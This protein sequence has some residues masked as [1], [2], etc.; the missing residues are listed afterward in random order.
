MSERSRSHIGTVSLLVAVGGTLASQVALRFGPFAG[1]EWLRIVGAGFEAAVVGALADWFA[2]TAL[3]RHPLGLPI[4]HTAIIPTRRARLTEGIVSMVQEEWLSPEVIESR[5]ARF[6]PS[7]VISDW[8]SDPE[9]VE[10]LGAPLRDLLHALADVLVEPEVRELAA[11]TLQRQLQAVPIDP[12]LG[13]SLARALE[14]T[15]A[16]AAFESAARSLAQLARRP[17]T[18]ENLQLWL[19]RS[20][21]QLH[22]EG[23]RLIPLILRRK[24]VQR[25]I[26][27]AACDY[28]TGELLG[29]ATDPAHPLR[30]SLFDA[31][32]RFAARIAAGEPELLAQ[33][34]RLRTAVVESLDTTPLLANALAGMRAQL[35]DDL[36][37]QDSHLAQLINRQLRSGI[38]QLLAD[39][40]RRAR[41]DEWVRGTAGDLLRRHHHQIGLTVRE[42]LEALDADALVAQ[43]E[44]RVGA[45]LQFI[46]LNGALVGGLIGLVLAA[47]H[48]LLH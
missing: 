21:E 40:Q 12:S 4:P 35:Q 1:A 10:R 48:A 33:I 11:A 31:A 47:I 6:S 39:P 15:S 27:E 2:V 46:R 13:T 32:R 8:L 23:K 41:I 36:R 34:E 38:R 44:E 9:H 14:S 43:I 20:A 22:R 45:D 26:V 30:R 28:A 17:E 7:E 29:A 18:A 19:A 5:L 42:N 24:L 37:N 3:F 25:A 16:A